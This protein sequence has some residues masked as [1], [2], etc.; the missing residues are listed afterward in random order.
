MAAFLQR[1]FTNPFRWMKK[2]HIL[3]QI[4]LKLVAK[5]QVN[6]IWLLIQIIAWFRS[7]IRHY[8][9]Q[10]WS[11]LLMHICITQAWWVNS[12]WPSVATWQHRFGS[13]LTQV[14]VAP[15]VTDW[16][17]TDGLHDLENI[18]LLCIHWDLNKME[19]NWTITQPNALYKEFSFVSLLKNY[20]IDCS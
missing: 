9:N 16:H 17:M 10:W 14:I 19:V 7:W 15:G 13:T 12:P 3:T 11:S 1:T 6:N 4:S 8:L 5:G 2:N 20:N 18:T